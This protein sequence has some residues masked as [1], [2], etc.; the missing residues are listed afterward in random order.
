MLI[1]CKIKG[2]GVYICYIDEFI[3]IERKKKKRLFFFCVGLG[4][5]K[6]IVWN[7]NYDIFNWFVKRFFIY[8]FG[9]NI[10]LFILIFR[11]FY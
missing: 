7:N 9:F 3:D 4:I 11:N 8:L 6:L 5:E 2:E 10:L 1:D